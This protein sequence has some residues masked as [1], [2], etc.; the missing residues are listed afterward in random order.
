MIVKPK[1]LKKKK[2]VNLYSRYGNQF[3]ASSKLKQT[4]K[5]HKRG[6]QV[7]A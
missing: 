5:P 1:N 2:N 4:Y 6:P 3:G 7:E